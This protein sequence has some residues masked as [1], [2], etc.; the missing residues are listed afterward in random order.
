MHK[1]KQKLDY[2]LARFSHFRVRQ[3]SEN[4][5]RF[6]AHFWLFQQSFWILLAQICPNGISVA[7]SALSFS[8]EI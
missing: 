5:C 6:A 3:N 8:V 1:V 7:P 2:R 4:N